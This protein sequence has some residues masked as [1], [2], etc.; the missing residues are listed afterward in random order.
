MKY[1]FSVLI[2][3]LAQGFCTAQSPA[4]LADTNYRRP[5]LLI[6]GK[7]ADPLS[8]MVLDEENFKSFVVLSPDHA[9]K[10]GKENVRFGAVEVT[11][12]NPKEV[13]NFSE[14]RSF[15]LFKKEVAKLP[16]V[17]NFGLYYDFL[18]PLEPKLFMA[19]L[20]MVQSMNVGKRTG[21]DFRL[22]LS[23]KWLDVRQHP[24][25]AQLDSL[26]ESLKMEAKRR[27][28]KDR[29]IIIR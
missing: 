10:Y 6:D 1:Y 2:L 29:E 12:L 28:P 24:E 23:K 11:T 18:S 15:F 25:N 5:Y 21:K 8:L 3:F 20:S 17:V 7:P 14:L 19:S 4:S 26:V 9:L 13:L 27:V 16:F 22:L